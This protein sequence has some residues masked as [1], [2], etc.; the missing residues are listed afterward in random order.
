MYLEPQDN[1]ELMDIELGKAGYADAFTVT[2]PENEDAGPVPDEKLR[3]AFDQRLPISMEKTGG[4][5]QKAIRDAVR[6][7][8]PDRYGL[9]IAKNFGLT[10]NETIKGSQTFGAEVAKATSDFEEKGAPS[11]LVDVLGAG[12]AFVSALATS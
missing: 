7:V 11:E 5:K 12:D 1:R 8:A 4:D 6:T 3:T 2:D 10:E 9:S